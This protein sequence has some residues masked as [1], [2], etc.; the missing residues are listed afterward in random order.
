MDIYVVLL[1]HVGLIKVICCCADGDQTLF[2]KTTVSYFVEICLDSFQTL[3]TV[4]F[5]LLLVDTT[6]VKP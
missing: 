6:A 4:Q 1:D 3:S 5:Q 2:C